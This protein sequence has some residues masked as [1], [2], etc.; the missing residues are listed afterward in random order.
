MKWENHIGVD[1]GSTAIKLVQLSSVGLGKFQLAALGQAA[2]GQDDPARV[3]AIKKL[4]AQIKTTVKTVIFSL[5]ESL[6]YTRVVEMP[7]L[8]EPELTSTIAFQAEQYIPVPLDDVILK[9]QVLSEPEPGVPGAKMSVLLVAVPNEVM[10]RYLQ[11]FSQA[12]LDVLAVETEILAVIRS[13]LSDPNAPTS[14]VVH[15]GAE[16]S[17]IAVARQGNLVLTQSIGYGGTGVA[18]ALAGN[19][20]M[21]QLQAQEYMRSYGLDETKLEGKVATAIKPVVDLIIGEIKRALAFYESKQVND[22]VK[23]VV[24]SGGLAQL[25]GLVQYAAIALGMEVQIG[26]PFASVGLT[27]MQKKDIGESGAVFTV[28]VGLAQKQT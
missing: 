10:N 23:R 25:S 26:N 27:D 22:P 12:G 7:Q 1:V 3:A 2:A 4:L 6:V 16:T 28:A 18:R 13:L 8:V 21:E 11:I 15:L 24:L 20:K 5:P 17:T 9:H 14:L 19:L